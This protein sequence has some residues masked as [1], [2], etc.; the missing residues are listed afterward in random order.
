M[1]LSL[2]LAL[3][4]AHVPAV[5]C[6]Q[7]PAAAATP[8]APIEVTDDGLV[9]TWYPPAA[10]KKGPVIVALG[11]SEGGTIGSKA[12]ARALAKQGYG[13]LALAYFGAPGLP[14]TLQNVPLEYF[15]HALAWVARQPLVDPKRI[16]IYG[17]SIGGETALLV[18]ARHPE[19]TAVVAAVPSS[20]VWQ[21]FDRRDYR[22]VE[23]TYSL[24]GK[25]IAYLPYD[26]SKPFTGVYALYADSLANV[27]AHPDAV[28]PVERIGG[29]VLLLSGD[30]DTLWPS[31]RMCEQIVERLKA[32]GFR[33]PYRH[34]AFADAGHGAF[35]PP[36]DAPARNSGYDNL[37]GT[38]AGNAAARAGMWQ[39]VTEFLAAQLIGK[40]KR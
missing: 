26:T 3:A 14:Q 1:R 8:A 31:R 5:A 24:G 10:G 33:N 9:A 39:A 25:G 30:A 35:A 19:I 18:A 12:L 2:C 17:I 7:A 15:D 4:L 27:S 21:G 29:A 20:V 23:S 38:E 36:S 34:L 40:A 6:A 13:V 37:G 32:H 11:G 22:S 16:A 28:I